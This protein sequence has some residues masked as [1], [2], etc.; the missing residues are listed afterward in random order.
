MDYYIIYK[1]FGVHSQFQP[2]GEQLGL[3]SLHE[4]PKDVYP[5]GRLDADSE[6]LLLLTNDPRVNKKLLDPT[7]KHYRTYYVQVEGTITQE[8]IDRLCKGVS[9]SIDGKEYRTAPA[10]ARIIESPELPERNPPI[11]FRKTVPDS[12][13][14]LSITEGKNRQ[15]KRMTA[16][17]GFPTLRLVRWKIEDLAM[18]HPESGKV[19]QMEKSEVYKKLKL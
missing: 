19:V 15:V 17:V 1:P 8:A 18:D 7:F 4:F 16:A 3:G 13:L 11:R 6:G 10:K 14:E 5:V 2:V 12:W 9:I